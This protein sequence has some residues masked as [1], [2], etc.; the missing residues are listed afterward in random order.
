MPITLNENVSLNEALETFGVSLEQ[1]IDLLPRLKAFSVA[2]QE[3]LANKVN[4]EDA[5]AEFMDY[6]QKFIMSLSKKV[7]EGIL[8][9]FT[10]FMVK[11][12][13][14]RGDLEHSVANIDD[15]DIRLFLKSGQSKQKNP[16]GTF[17]EISANTYNKRLAVLSAYSKY[18][19]KQGLI[20]TSLTSEI[21]YEKQGELPIMF[22]TKE[23]QR[24]VLETALK[25]KENGK[26]DFFFIFI[27]LNSGLRAEEIISLNV[28][29]IDLHGDTII[30]RHGKG[31]KRREVYLTDE[32][33][34]A[35]MV[36]IKNVRLGAFRDRKKEVP[37][38]INMK[39][40]HFGQRMTKSAAE[41]M[42]RGVFDKVGI[43][44][45]TI[46]RL[47]HTFAVNCLEAGMKINEIQLLLGHANVTTTVRYLRLDNERIRREIKEKY[48]LAAVSINNF[49][50]WL[51]N[52]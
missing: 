4:L 32:A 37:L 23:Q 28:D 24:A 35:C 22:L 11:Q 39:G 3:N 36:Y 5:I 18:L 45:G 52:V 41:E 33:K 48:P 29:D 10:A 9:Q 2:N 6:K 42:V 38:F 17:G 46:H 27:G 30:V 12:W 43:G 31:D 34:M 25:N 7:Y 49:E 44:R 15:A 13:E 40:A 20:T 21:K 26:R 50:Q 19:V 16:D 47:R 14:I 51:G 1:F 8:A